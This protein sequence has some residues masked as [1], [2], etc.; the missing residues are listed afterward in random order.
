MDEQL[1]AARLREIQQE[2]LQLNNATYAMAA[3][4]KQRYP[5]NF[6]EI[7]L[8]TAVRA[9]RI[10]CKMRHLIG[11]YGTVKPSALMGQAI[12]AQG[13]TIQEDE[14]NGTVVISIPRLLPRWKKNRSG[15]FL[16]RPLQYALEQYCREH[17]IR[18][19]DV[20]AVCFVHIYDQQL[21]LGRIR[22]Y[23]NLQMKHVLDTIATYLMLDDNGL[24][25]DVYHSSI[26]GETDCTRI[27]V[28]PQPRL[29][30]FISELKI[31]P[32]SISNLR[33]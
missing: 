4:D 5:E 24:L 22:D 11:A 16:N 30:D 20:C 33:T 25:C 28:M 9:E 13:I 7:S 27:Y 29:P 18:K 10:A 19:Y 32:E 2:I 31:Y 21:S 14:T 17:P 3:Y 6:L 15:E 1:Y 12:D 23:D 8:D 26:Y